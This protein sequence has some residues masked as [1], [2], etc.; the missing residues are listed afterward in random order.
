MSTFTLRQQCRRNVK[1]QER[2]CTFK[3][4]IFTS[5]K[6]IAKSTYINNFFQ[7]TRSFL[8]VIK[9]AYFSFLFTF[10]ALEIKRYH[11]SLSLP[12]KNIIYPIWS[13]WFAEKLYLKKR[14]LC[15]IVKTFLSLLSGSWREK[16]VF[17]SRFVVAT[18]LQ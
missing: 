3:I 6:K 2:N 16:S 13:W 10:L 17:V 18:N 14:G 8:H 12:G 1:C 9:F 11:I 5:W 15:F 4:P 7:L